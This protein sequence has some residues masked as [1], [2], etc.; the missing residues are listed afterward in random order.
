MKSC[1]YTGNIRHRRFVPHRHEFN[2]PLFMVYLDL[3]ECEAVFALSRWWSNTG[4]NLAWLRRKD[5][6]APQ[7]LSI[8]QAVVE[9]L[10]LHGVTDFSGSVRMLA[11]LRYFG[12]CFNPVTFYFCFHEGQDQPAFLV[13]DVH[14][15]PWNERHVYVLSYQEHAAKTQP[16]QKSLNG[17]H[18][19]SF[20]KA[21]HVSPF[22]P[23]N[24]HYR[25]SIQNPGDALQIHIKALRDDAKWF[26]ATLDMHKESLCK[27][28]MHRILWRYPLMTLQ[29]AA[30]IYWQALRL[31][32][33]KT[34]TFD[35]PATH[36]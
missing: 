11:H 24:M 8:K 25:W 29:V 16:S 31:W 18:V 10:R 35:H 27:T 7:E 19:F 5:Y 6:V 4:P 17:K 20:E 32:L 36:S 30:G 15:T 23:M 28:S 9:Q 3:D 22:N 2:Y 26:D 1:L 34:P 12:H 14:N 21:F 33:R 13:A